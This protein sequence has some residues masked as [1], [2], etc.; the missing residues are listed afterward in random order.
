VLQV[1]GSTLAHVN[2]HVLKDCGDGIGNFC[3]FLV[4]ALV[5]QGALLN[6]ATVLVDLD[7]AS[8]FCIN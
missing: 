1:L 7:H 2:R 6:I 4:G 8:H 3:S 5:G